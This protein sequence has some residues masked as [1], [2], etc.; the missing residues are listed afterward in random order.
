MTYHP[1]DVGQI[2][3]WKPVTWPINTTRG[4]KT[5]MPYGEWCQ[6]EARKIGGHV[7]VRDVSG[8]TMV[9]IFE[10]IHTDAGRR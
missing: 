2:T 10:G 5:I 1:K 3:H 8:V 6:R 9:S 7:K 4:P